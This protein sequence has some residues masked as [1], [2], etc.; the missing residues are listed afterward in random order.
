MSHNLLARSSET[1]QESPHHRLGRSC[2]LSKL[3]E[4]V[5][6][7]IHTI[8]IL[9]FVFLLIFMEQSCLTFSYAE[10]FSEIMIRMQRVRK[11]GGLREVLLLQ[12]ENNQ[13]REVL[14]LK[15]ENNQHRK[16]HKCL[17]TV[18]RVMN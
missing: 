16:C 5:A 12:L 14:L 7:V 10:L 3:H 15:L 17:T 6:D 4:E 18:Q 2:C 13:H 11:K 8:Y 9:S 1:K